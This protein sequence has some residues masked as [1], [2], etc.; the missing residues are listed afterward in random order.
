MLRD[1][2]GFPDRK[3]SN[4]IGEYDVIPNMGSK[5]IGVAFRPG[6]PFIVEYSK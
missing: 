6:C 5:C 1:K 3:H 4:D 2:G